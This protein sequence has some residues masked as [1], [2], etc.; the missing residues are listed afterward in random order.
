MQ[1]SPG[2]GSQR[3]RPDSFRS[4]VRAC[5]LAQGLCAISLGVSEFL[6]CL[7]Q[8]SAVFQETVDTK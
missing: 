8:A 5:A 2:A 6:F 1:E 3:G 7:F 4:G